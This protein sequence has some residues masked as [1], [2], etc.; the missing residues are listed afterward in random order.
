MRHCLLQQLNTLWPLVL[1]D[2]DANP[3]DVAAGTREA[4]HNATLDWLAEDTGNRDCAGSRFNIEHKGRGDGDDQI[5]VPTNYLA[6]EVRIM[7]GVPFTGISLDQEIA[8]FDIA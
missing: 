1:S 7:V 3:R 8:P 6:S 2:I 5:W 4:R